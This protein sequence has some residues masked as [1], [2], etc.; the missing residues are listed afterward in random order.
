MPMSHE[1]IPAVRAR[2]GPDRRRGEGLPSPLPYLW[3]SR[4]GLL[5]IYSRVLATMDACVRAVHACVLD[6][7]LARIFM[8]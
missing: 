8:F 7:F 5:R 2:S 6:R 1:G 4:L 3:V